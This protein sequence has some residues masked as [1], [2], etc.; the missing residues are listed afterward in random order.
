MI[1][2]FILIIYYLLHELAHAFVKDPEPDK[3]EYRYFYKRTPDKFILKIEDE[4]DSQEAGNYFETNIFGGRLRFGK[5][6]E[7][8]SELILQMLKSNAPNLK[9]FLKEKKYVK[10]FSDK[11]NFIH[12]FTGGDLSLEESENSE[13]EDGGCGTNELLLPFY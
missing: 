3:P 8:E 4:K 10:V 5:I 2:I 6:S 1:P 7:D 12:S 11:R 13:L 9:E